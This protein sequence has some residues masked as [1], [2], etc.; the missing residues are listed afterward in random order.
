MNSFI[1]FAL[2]VSAQPSLKSSA[3]H[4]KPKSKFDEASDDEDDM[5]EIEKRSEALIAYLSTQ[6]IVL[7]DNLYFPVF[8]SML[9]GVWDMLLRDIEMLLFPPASEFLEEKKPL[10][11]SEDYRDLLP[12]LVDVSRS[13]LTLDIQLNL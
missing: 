5:T 13:F 8:I 12:Q 3:K 4:K 1:Q 9:H 2:E 11:V 10:V 7:S 6:L